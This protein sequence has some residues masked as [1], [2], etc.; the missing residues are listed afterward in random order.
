MTKS[1]QFSTIK[2]S[3]LDRDEQIR[4]AVAIGKTSRISLGSQQMCR[5]LARLQV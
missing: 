3:M 2:K 5:I 1:D 4:I